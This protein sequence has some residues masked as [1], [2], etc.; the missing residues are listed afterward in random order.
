MTAELPDFIALRAR[1]DDKSFPSGAKAEL[2]RVAEPDDL[3]LTTALYRLFPGARPDDRH[4]RLAY[5]LPWCKH[6]SKTTSL[7]VQLAEAKVAEARVLQ[8]AR[9]RAPLDLV[10]LRRL[11]MHIEPAVD[12]TAFGRTLWF[13]GERAKRE[14]VEDFYITRFKPAKGENK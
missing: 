11:V 13:W 9:A 4:L 6:A 12:W 5:L 3:A 1:Y 14:I 2:R 7:G 10:Q 8:T